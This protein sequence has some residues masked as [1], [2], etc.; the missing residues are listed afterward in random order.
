MDSLGTQ[1]YHRW[2]KMFRQ[3]RQ[4]SSKRKLFNW[5]PSR[6]WNNYGN[7]KLATIHRSKLH[8]SLDDI[9]KLSS[10]IFE[11]DA[12]TYKPLKLKSL[13]LNEL[14][15]VKSA[16][17]TQR[18]QLDKM[19]DYPVHYDNISVWTIFLYIFIV[20]LILAIIYIFRNFSSKLNNINLKDQPKNKR[21][22]FRNLDLKNSASPWIFG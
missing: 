22:S 17:E 19:D 5:S 20:L 2:T 8:S 7:R 4:R 18:D 10:P 16:L 12:Y 13:N 14:Q 21:K 1:Q 3:N 9:P 11:E 6:L 15:S